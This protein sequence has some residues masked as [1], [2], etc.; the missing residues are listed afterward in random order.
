MAPNEPTS[1]SLFRR[2]ARDYSDLIRR[3]PRARAY[4]GATLIDDVGIAVS[5]WATALMMT[6]L[7]TTQR[8]R[9]SLMLPTL[10]CFLVG[11]LVSGPLA[12]WAM[13]TAASSLA[14]LARWRWKVVLAGRAVETLLLGVVVV[15]LTMGP[16]TVA[17]VLP[18]IMVAAFMKTALRATRI[19]FSVDLLQEE[20]PLQGPSGEAL[21]DERGQP[22]AYK[23]HLVT[24]SSLTSFLATL[25]LLVGLLAGRH[26]MALAGGRL[27]ILFGADIVTNLGFMAVVYLGCRPARAALDAILPS[28]NVTSDAVTSVVV[29]ERGR[30]RHFWGSFADGFRFLAAPSRRPLLALLAGSWLVEVITESFDGKMVIKHVLH[31]GDEGLRHAEIVWTVVAAVGA[32]L[33]PLLVRRV[34]SLGKIFLVTMFFDGL[35]IAVAGYVAGAAAPVVLLPFTAAL[36]VD[37]SLTLASTTLTEIAQNSISSAAMRGR[38]AGTF[39]LCVIVGD[40]LSE[41]L[42]SVAEQRWGIPGLIVRVGFLQVAVVTLIALGGGRKL[43]SFGLRS[44]SPP[45]R[46]TPAPAAAG[47]HATV[48]S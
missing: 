39:A 15:Q 8:A 36:A 35:V 4:L 11:T 25:A 12:D 23:K 24:F 13:R 34:S 45:A 40:M 44:D 30:F 32:A 27:W 9:A 14:G 33:L 19:A 38:I 26:V 22:L 46:E 10:L 20:T 7:A 6:N 31:G 41:G 3:E 16:P 48:G 21:L 43:W 37:R 29:A 42:A 2:L 1:P 47:A 5:A 28:A 17:R 18:Y